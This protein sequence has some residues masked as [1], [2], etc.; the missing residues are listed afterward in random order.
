MPLYDYIC[1]ENGQ[2]VEV[3][4]R[5]NEKMLTWGQLCEKADIDPGTTSKDTQVNRVFG[6]YSINV[7][8]DVPKFDETILPK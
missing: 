3:F 7:L 5:M 6:G 8:A 4:H 1:K 2:T